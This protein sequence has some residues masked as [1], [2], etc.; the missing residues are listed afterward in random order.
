MRGWPEAGPA[1][2]GTSAASARECQTT[3]RRAARTAAWGHMMLNKFKLE[4]NIQCMVYTIY[5]GGPQTKVS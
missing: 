5:Q 1:L 3:C 4:L 2:T